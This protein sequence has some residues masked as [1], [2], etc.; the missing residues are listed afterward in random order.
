MT[1]LFANIT[2]KQK[3]KLLRILEANTLNFSKNCQVLTSVKWDNIIGVVIEGYMQITRTDYNGNR[4][5]IEEL[6]ENS[7]FGT[8]LSSLKNNEYDIITKENTKIVVIEYTSIINEVDNNYPYY[9]QFMKN[10]LEII[11]EKINE[12]NARI[13][14]LTKK[15]IRDKLLEYFKIISK[16][17]GSKI[18]YLSLNYSEL[19]DYLAVD[20]SAMSRELKNLINEGFI[21]KEGK[22][23]TLLY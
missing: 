12:K 23:I 10:L 6:D 14:I 8:T 3:E 16:K 21:K 7:I 15:S 5:I 18:I 4:T 9:N 20:R 13:E 22:K 1:N 17:N 19:A 2:P 11:N